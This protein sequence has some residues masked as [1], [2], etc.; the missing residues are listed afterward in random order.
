MLA[1]LLRR[2]ERS[3]FPA[4]SL[5]EM[6]NSILFNGIPYNAYQ[7]SYGTDQI[8]RTGYGFA[9]LAATYASN[10]VVFAVILARLQLFTEARFKFRPLGNSQTGALFGTPALRPLETPWPNGTTGDLLARMEQDVSLAGNAYVVREG[11]RLFRLRPDF[12]DVLLDRPAYD[13]SAVAVGYAYNDPNLHTP[14]IYLAEQVAHWAPIPDPFAHYRGMSWLQPIVNELDADRGATEHKR[15]FFENAATPNLAVT[16][17]K[18]IDPDKFRRFQELFRSE[19]GGSEN[20]YKTLF[21]GGG[22]DVKVVGATFEQ[23]AFKA[24]QGA[25]ETRIAAAGGVPPVLVGLSEGLMAS[26]YSNAQQARRLFA[27]K[28]ARPQWRS[29][30]GALA[31][32]VAV[33]PGAELWYDDRDIAFVREDLKDEAEANQILANTVRTLID[34]GYMPDGVVNAVTTGDFTALTGNHSNL[35]SVQ[36]R[37]PGDHDGDGTVD[38]DGVASDPHKATP[39]ELAEMLQKIYLAVGKVITVDEAREIVSSAGADLPAGQGPPDPVAEPASVIPSSEEG[40]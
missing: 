22:A 12:V 29:V 24:T 19:H 2:T 34:A 21:L 33:P 6:L 20:A 16:L 38:G 26:T 9:P 7:T 4:M 14:A 39:R 27:D 37:P 18:E 3:Q 40:Q 10:G 31:K 28:W 35:F 23:M 17:A 15:K 30:S 25:G 36:L 32:L 5:N 1:K 8:E 11:D 13:P